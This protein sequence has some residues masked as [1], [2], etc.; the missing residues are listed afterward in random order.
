[1]I[2]VASCSH[3]IDM[4]GCT[5][6]PRVSHVEDSTTLQICRTW[7]IWPTSGP[8]ASDRLPL[9]NGAG[10][11]ARGVVFQEA[12]QGN[13]VAH[14]K[15]AVSDGGSK[16]VQEAGA[17]ENEASLHIFRKGTN[18]AMGST[19]QGRVHVNELVITAGAAA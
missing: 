6:L 4:L 10:T 13:A 14:D 2:E 11:Q 17:T 15:M 7:R 1:M 19:R 12:A 16:V 5:N 9:A 8:S 3:L 18:P